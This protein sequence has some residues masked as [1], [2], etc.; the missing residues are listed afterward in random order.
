MA[1]AVLDVLEEEGYLGPEG[2][3]SR[4]AQALG[5]GLA[6]LQAQGV[7]IT[8]IRQAGLMVGVDLALPASGVVAAAEEAG[9]LINA[10]GPHTLRLL[11]PYTLSPEELEEGL[12]KLERALAQAAGRA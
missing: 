6:H 7:P 5:R 3:I 9:L 11:P 1:L 2:R 4:L 12:A 10:T 8:A